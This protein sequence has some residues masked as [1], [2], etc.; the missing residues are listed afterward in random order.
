MKFW[1]FKAAKNGK[2]PELLV[3]GY[4]G[5]WMDVDSYEFAHQL[6]AIDSEE[7]D[8]R[9][10]SDGG[11]VFTAQAI[12]S[13]LRRHKARINVFI[14]GIA[15]S[16]AT[17]I[18]MAGDKII[19]P[20]NAMMMVHNPLLGVFANANEM[21]EWAETLDKV[22]DT[23]VAVYREKTGLNDEK[24]IELMDA[25]TYMTASEAVELGFADKIEEHLRIAATLRRDK[26]IVNGIEMNT[27]RLSNMPESWLTQPENTAQLPSK[28]GTAGN[29]NEETKEITIMNLDQLKADHPELYQ[30]VLN[31]GVEAG[32]EQER[33]RIQAIEDLEMPGHEALAAKAKFETMITAE[34][35]AMEVIK[36]ERENK[37]NFIKNRQADAEPLNNV[38][39]T[40]DA[41]AS[42]DKG[43]EKRTVAVNSIAAAFSARN[44]KKNIGKE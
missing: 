27:K 6:K 22:R 42:E 10:N 26:M 15:A 41:S 38:T 40:N 5:E 18:A 14:D 25:E 12:Y 24:I 33:A 35:F 17:L 8:V 11:S 3:Y 31:Q 39:P 34:A 23:I 1:N 44:G 16:A 36:A 7:I 32:K 21:R 2:N 29:S 43:E 13:S 28:S 19:M 4:I 30:Q 9:I 37:Q 20:A